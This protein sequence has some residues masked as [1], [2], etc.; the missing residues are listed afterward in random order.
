MHRVVAIPVLVALAAVAAPAASALPLRTLRDPAF[1]TA[2]PAGW[3]ERTV[4]DHRDRTYFLNSGSG[5]ANNLGLPGR[6][7]IGLTVGLH[8]TARGTSAR[9]VLL[10]FVGYPA[11]AKELRVSPLHDAHL[12]GAHA[13]TITLRY[14]YK[15]V[16]W[17]QR[18]LV[19]VHGAKVGF[20]EVDA[21]P[22]KARS[23]RRT[24]AA[25]EHHWHW[26]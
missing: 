7:Q 1:T 9:H 18:D 17:V 10:H 13:A 14:R 26:R 25:V 8:H 24:M 5:H 16:R 4:K 12:A 20:I 6:G 22:S 2:V 15:G 11:G 21:G 3:H 23:A 19:A